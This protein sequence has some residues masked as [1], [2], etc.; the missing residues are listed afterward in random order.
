MLSKIQDYFGETSGNGLITH[1]MNVDTK[2]T[3]LLLEWTRRTASFGRLM[4]LCASSSMH[5]RATKR[6]ANILM[7]WVITSA[8]P[9]HEVRPSVGIH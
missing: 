8:T 6:G 1:T 3:S 9:C 2:R 4:H 5:Q 7:K